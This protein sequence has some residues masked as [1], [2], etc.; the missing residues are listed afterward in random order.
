MNA[1][2]QAIKYLELGWSVFPI[3]PKTKK[4]RYDWKKYQT[5]RMTIEEAR[6]QFL[7]G[8]NI[9]LV[10]GDISGILAIDLDT[11]KETFKKLD[12]EIASS[13]QVST[14]RGGTHMYFKYKEGRANTANN[15]LATDIRGKGGYVLVPQS[16]FYDPDT[17]K[18]GSYEWNID[19]IQVIVDNLPE[20]PV[21]A[22]HKIYK[23]D[24]D[25]VTG[26]P[27]AK[28]PFEVMSALNVVDGSRN[29]TLHRLAVSLL[30]KHDENTAHALLVAANQTAVPPLPEKDIE[31]MWGSALK[32]VRANPP[33]GQRTPAKQV[34]ENVG[35]KIPSTND[36]YQSAITTFLEGKQKGISSGFTELDKITGGLI[37]GQ[38]YLLFADTNVG[39]SVFAVNIVVDLAMRGYR[40]TYFDL[41]NSMS[42]SME[43]MMFAANKGAVSVTEWR[44]A[45]EGKDEKSIIEKM[46]A[47]TPLLPNLYIWD[48]NN[49]NERFGEII[50]EGVERCIAEA[51][52]EKVQIVVIDHLHY[53][54]PS[55]TDHAILGEIARKLNSL[56]SVEN[57]VVILVAHTKKG[58]V[59]VNKHGK[60]GATRPTIDSISGSSLIS[61]H[62]KNI[63]GI[64]RNMASADIN[65]RCETWFHVDKTKYGPSGSFKL[66]Y[67]EQSLCF[68][69]STLLP[70]GEF[71]AGE[72]L[73]IQPGTTSINF[74]QE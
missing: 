67:N 64:Q 3:L 52:K 68:H 25:A 43:R 56:A 40:T 21:E 51:V 66:L 69:D 32:F 65:E 50:W 10:C 12:V 13:L 63:I 71:M 15:D 42:M 14:P 33:I 23:E 47:L 54:S 48:L 35:F 36:N 58:L 74:K 72:Q 11:Y 7:H 37:P 30:N 31:T 4:P 55:E 34:I 70:S 53:F 27:I 16:V 28:A 38:S 8:D 73:K 9:A 57:I 45:L 44:K 2:E 19:P 22:L 46:S 59:W 20:V 17:K 18:T 29:D 1:A 26:A 5:E 24:V 60:V 41:E 62:F 6:K 39:K 61:K 49:L